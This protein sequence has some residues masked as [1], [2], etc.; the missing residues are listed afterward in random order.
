MDETIKNK[1]SILAEAFGS[2]K[3]WVNWENVTKRPLQ[4]SGDSASIKD[5]ATLSTYEEVAKVSSNVGIVFTEDK[6]LLGIDMDDCIVD[7]VIQH[8]Q[9]EKIKL[10]IEKANTYT[11]ISPSGTGLHCFLQVET[12]I[13]LEA[14]RKGSFEVYN[15]GRYFTVTNNPF[16]EVKPLRTVTAEEAIKLLEILGYPWGKKEKE[17]EKLAQATVVSPLDDATII[18]K[19]FESKAG[20]KIKTLYSGDITLYKGDDSAADMALCS[21]LAFWCAKDPVQIERI[22]IASPLGKREKTQQRKDYRDRTINVAIASC[23]EVYSPSEEEGGD[24]F[25]NEKKGQADKI[26]EMV[27]KIEGIDLFHDDQ[28]T[29]YIAMKVDDHNEIIPL[30]SKKFQRWL[31]HEYRR[32]Y[33]KVIS[34]EAIKSAV[35]VLEGKACL[36]GRLS[37]LENR[38]TWEKDE[39]WYDLTNNK[40]QAIKVN[41]EGWD[42]VDKPPV[43]FKRYPHSQPQVIPVKVG[44]DIKLILKYVNISKPE[45]QLLLLTYL[46]SSFIP[47]FPH[48]ILVIYGPQGSAKSTLSRILRRIVDPSQIEVSSMPESQRELIQALAHH[49]FLFFDNISY[50]SEE[51]SDTLCKAITGSGFVKRELYTNDEDIIYK[52]KRAIG[53]NGINLVSTR[54]DLLDRSLLLELERI[55][56]KDRKTEKELMDDF[57]KDLPIILGGIFDI[58]KE[59]LKIKPEVKLKE[60]PRMADFALWGAAIAKGLGS[61]QDTFLLAY[62]DNIEKQTETILNENTVAIVLTS[63]IDHLSVPMWKGTA[64]ELLDELKKHAPFAHVDIYEKY[65]PKAPQ[66]LSRALNI[67]KVTL[68]E[69]DLA[70]S[71][72]AG[73]KRQITIEKISER[74][75]LK[76]E[77]EI[78]ENEIFLANPLVQSIFR[79][80]KDNTDG[81]DDVPTI[82]KGS[83]PPE[84]PSN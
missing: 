3:R 18:Q 26:V 66:T 72:S 21:Y 75:R 73:K 24:D 32:N 10:F 65:W 70:I 44:G 35:S 7:W 14:N 16:S 50:I 43:L 33:K 22:W 40:W 19:M 13:A 61:T 29:S 25:G 27:E 46:V 82:L 71:I 62:K 79:Q 39:L 45:Q 67:L 74:E 60:L 69:A 58:L 57:E 31:R 84:A 83:L 54:P 23:N 4:P 20:E 6:L 64:S 63:F 49:A 80:I 78:R 17:T 41:K 12:P 36:E 28:M 48:P 51:V 34:T 15:S 37:K 47:D 53:I 81:S 1:R 38:L 55:E 68:R 30:E 56:E 77:A 2:Q 11:E 9:E 59:T 76:K 42:I 8:E 5:L 52:L